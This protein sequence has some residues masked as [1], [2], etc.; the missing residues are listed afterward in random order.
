MNK[1]NSLILALDVLSRDK[2]LELT[3]Q[4]VDHFDAIKVG[5]PLILHAGLGIV[6][7]ISSISPVIAD[8]KIADTPNTNRLICEAVLGA[9]AD[10]IIAQAFPGKDSLVA[11]AD[12]AESFGADLFV[13]TEMSHP[14]AE[15]FMAPLAERMARL[16]V[17]SGA[18]GVVAPATRPE[19][20]RMIRSIIGDK[21]IISPGVGAQGGSAGEALQA[22][23]DYLIVGRSVYGSADPVAQAKELAAQVEQSRRSN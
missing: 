13:V 10:A 14:G 20:I 23:A 16:A 15:Q 19:R 6:E 21:L 4:L 8:L 17:E 11:C 3:E 7:E 5:Y 2:A 18:S 12:C 9:G 1:K 22:G